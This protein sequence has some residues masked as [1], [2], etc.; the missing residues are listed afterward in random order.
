MDRY[1][2]L[3]TAVGAGGE[4]AAVT[5]HRPYQNLHDKVSPQG[6]ALPL[7]PTASR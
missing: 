6:S 3:S 2:A 7:S 4:A 1:C 5:T